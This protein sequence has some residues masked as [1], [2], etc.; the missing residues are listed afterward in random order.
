MIPSR[1]VR[2]F[3]ERKRNDFRKFKDYDDALLTR[4]MR[5]LPMRPPIWS[6][7]RRHQKACLLIGAAVKRFA[8]FLDTGMG[9]TLLA[10]ALQR[11]FRKRNELQ[12]FCL[13]LVP[14]RTNKYEWKREIKKHSPL[15]SCVILVGSSVNKWEQLRDCKAHIVVETYAGLSRMLTKMG[16]TKK[17]KNKLKFNPTLVKRLRAMM[18]ML[19]MDESTLVKSRRSLA[20][21]FCLHVSKHIDHVFA[22]TGTP[23]G[24][25]ISDLQP[26]MLIVDKGQTL[27]ETL[28]LFRGAF[29]KEKQGAWATEYTFD[30]KKERLL[31]TYLA[32]SSIT[33][34]ADAADLPQLVQVTNY[35]NLPR[36]AETLYESAKEALITGYG[37]YSEQKN[38]FMR[39]RQ[40]SSG[41]LGYVDDESGTRA[42]FEFSP[43]PKLETLITKIQEIPTHKKIIVY[44]DFIFT[45][46]MIA[47]ELTRLKIKW[48]RINGATDDPE[49][50][51]ARFDKDKNVQVLLLNNA[52]GGFGLNLQIA[53]Y[54][55]FYE[56]PLSLIMGKQTVKRFHR[57]YSTH[58]TVFRYDFIT[59]GTYDQQ[60]L[61][62]HAAGRKVFDAII[63]DRR[64]TS[65]RP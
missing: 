59:R 56:V 41:W 61:D 25:D 8:F 21:R 55:M 50:T 40:L 58:K 31:H 27:G 28:A 15:T 45:G 43:N 64:D 54:G 9:K 32:S 57:Q 62:N 63:H 53:Q 7:L 1:Q 6:V 23:F 2:K 4:L 19:V 18:S 17:G 3:H 51:L 34:E 35:I 11:Y 5:K 10:I 47:R 30:K 33:Y 14:N 38:A 52:A 29:F 44:H 22:M 36:D 20:F 46:T 65:R 60:I 13:V 24:A 12:G 26:Q 42:Q 48:L 49:E 16:K 37:N 39:M